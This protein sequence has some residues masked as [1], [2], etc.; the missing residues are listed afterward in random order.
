MLVLTRRK[1]ENILIGDHVEIAI[2]NVN[3]KEKQAKI[4]IA[5]T[6]KEIRIGDKILREDGGQIT[7]CLSADDENIFIGDDIEIAL[8]RVQRG[9]ARLGINAPKDIPIIRKE[10]VPKEGAAPT[11]EREYEFTNGQCN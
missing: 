5:V 11:Q 2:I 10:L 1:G 6:D 8:I 3:D 9:Q 4:G 7:L